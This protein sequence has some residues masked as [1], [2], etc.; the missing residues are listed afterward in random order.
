MNGAQV[1]S[2]QTVGNAPTSW[3]VSAHHFDL[4]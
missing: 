3:D 2:A 4:V 1:L